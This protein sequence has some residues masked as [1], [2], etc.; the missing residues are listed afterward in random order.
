MHTDL[1]HQ[2]L[3]V[4]ADLLLVSDKHLAVLVHRFDESRLKLEKH[5]RRRSRPK[6]RRRGNSVRWIGKHERCSSI[7]KSIGGW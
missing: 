2:T 6:R 4:V 5:K 7:V 1:R 3:V